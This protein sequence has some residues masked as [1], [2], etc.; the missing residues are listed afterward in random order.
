MSDQPVREH[1][2]AM[3]DQLRNVGLLRFGRVRNKLV[4]S[5]RY[6][7]EWLEDAGAFPLAPS[8]PL[9]EQPQHFSSEPDRK[10]AC[11][12]GAISDAAPDAWGRAIMKCAAGRGLDELEYLLAVDDRT[13]QGALRMLDDNETPLANDAPPTPRLVELPRLHRLCARLQSG[14]G[15]L[16]QVA[17]ELRGATASLGGA[18]PKAVVAARDGSLHVAKF[19]TSQDTRPH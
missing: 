6:F 13:R 17:L 2:V 4:S 5:F 3:G 19:T 1:I 10:E 9:G 7:P 14:G 16:R 8:L 12:P 15:D 11:L 18:R